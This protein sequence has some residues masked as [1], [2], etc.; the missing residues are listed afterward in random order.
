MFSSF[1][2]S[3]ASKEINTSVDV[4]N[5][6]ELL[7]AMIVTTSVA[8]FLPNPRSMLLQRDELGDA[9]DWVQHF[10]PDSVLA[11]VQKKSEE[12]PWEQHGL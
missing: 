12:E 3:N 4:L 11:D 5:L 6:L 10:E 7:T 1:A 9:L 2:Y 8:R